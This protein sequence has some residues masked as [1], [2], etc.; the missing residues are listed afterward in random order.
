MLVQMPQ[1]APPAD[2]GP[3]GVRTDQDD[4][5]AVRSCLRQLRERRMLLNRL[6]QRLERYSR[7]LPANHRTDLSLRD[8]N[9]PR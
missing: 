8:G 2:A 5:V 4:G 7:Q 6:I 1:I 3:R 9:P